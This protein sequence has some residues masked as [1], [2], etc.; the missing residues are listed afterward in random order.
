MELAFLE[1]PKVFGRLYG[2][3]GLL[4]YLWF[5][6]ALM[7]IAQ[8]TDTENS[9]F[10]WIPILN[11]YLMC[12]IAKKPVWWLILFFIPLVNIIVLVLVWMGIAEARGKPSWWGI[13]MLFPVLNLIIISLIAF[14]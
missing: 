6:Y 11:I 2:G 4:A 10:A 8:K 5:A 1:T 12:K 13:L 14:T 3:M 7:V 9:W